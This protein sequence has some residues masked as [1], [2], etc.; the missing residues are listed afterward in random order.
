MPGKLDIGK[1]AEYQPFMGVSERKTFSNWC[2]MHSRI[3]PVFVDRSA[4]EPKTSSSG[5]IEIP[6]DLQLWELAGVARLI[7]DNGKTSDV[8]AKISSL[9]KLFEKTAVYI[10]RRQ[11]C[12][13]EGRQLADE[14]VMEFYRYGKSLQVGEEYRGNEGAREIAREPLTTGETAVID[15]WLAGEEYDKLLLKAQKSG[16]VEHWRRKMLAKY[17]RVS[18]KLVERN[19]QEIGGVRWA[20]LEKI[21]TDITRAIMGPVMELDSLI[22][23]LG[24]ETLARG[25][26][27]RHSNLFG[28]NRETVVECLSLPFWRDQLERIRREGNPRKVGDLEIKTAAAF[29]KETERLPWKGGSCKPMDAVKNQSLSC[30]SFS[31][32]GG[33][34]FEEVGISYLSASLIDHSFLI[35]VTTDGRLVWVDMANS[36]YFGEVAGGDVIDGSDSI[37]SIV[38][39]LRQGGFFSGWLK[40]RPRG[41]LL[42]QFDIAGRSDDFAVR[43][44]FSSGSKETQAQMMEWLGEDLRTGGDKQAA[45]VVYRKIAYIDKYYITMN[46]ARA[47][48]SPDWDVQEAFYLRSARFGEFRSYYLLGE[49]YE[50][51]GRMREAKMMYQKYIEEEYRESHRWW[52][53]YAKYRIKLLESAEKNREGRLAMGKHLEE[54][55]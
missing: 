10:A 29:Q 21:K 52:I 53:N 32:L 36:H 16:S 30:I 51:R 31:M 27:S 7:G 1:I 38:N 47:M 6:R 54:G 40:I 19:E 11:G 35:L 49:L 3:R 26:K 2:E 55:G 39:K 9:G 4:C 46:K 18:D 5:I 37:E 48:I 33:R 42:D 14:M 13:K 45:S 34:L 22:F 41:A 20:Y 15:R 28:N 44:S 43:V 24:E 12:V 25:M 17:F 23:S 50:G 8:E